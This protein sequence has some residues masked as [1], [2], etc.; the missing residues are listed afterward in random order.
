MTATVPALRS[1]VT[2]PSGPGTVTKHVE[3]ASG[4]VWIRVLLD[5]GEVEWFDADQVATR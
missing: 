4:T 1:S 3:G 5:T 2:T